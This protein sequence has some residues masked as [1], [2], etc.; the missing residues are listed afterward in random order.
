M[1]L[2]LGPECPYPI[3]ADGVG[4]LTVFAAL[5]ELFEWFLRTHLPFAARLAMRRLSRSL[6]LYMHVHMRDYSDELTFLMA[7]VPRILRPAP[8][9]QAW[10]PFDLA[11]GQYKEN[12]SFILAPRAS[13]L[14]AA[15]TSHDS[16][17]RRFCVIAA[18]LHP[19]TCV[20]PTVA[21]NVFTIDLL[22]AR[23]IG[24]VTHAPST[25]GIWQFETSEWTGEQEQW[26]RSPLFLPHEQQALCDA[27]AARHSRT[28]F[29]PAPVLHIYATLCGHTVD[30]V[31]VDQGRSPLD[32]A[33]TLR[34]ARTEMNTEAHLIERGDLAVDG[35]FILVHRL[36][37]ANAEAP[38]QNLHLLV[39]SYV[40]R[41]EKCIMH[42][43]HGH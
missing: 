17:R 22:R 23:V 29:T 10:R 26:I 12:L 36:A 3:H 8:W 15:L 33:I 24:S 32:Y 14:Q 2:L 28:A 7:L 20:A 31:L 11:M 18:R 41:S 35:I 37:Y 4:R 38:E 21:T 19:S 1:N 39:M 40:G 6:S 25:H 34:R 30:T 43:P 5:T 27:Y 16:T 9:M 42:R 13:T